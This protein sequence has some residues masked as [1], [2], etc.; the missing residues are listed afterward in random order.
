MNRRDRARHTRAVKT[1]PDTGDGA[2]A[3]GVQD[4]CA[5]AP[6]SLSSGGGPQLQAGDVLARRYELQHLLGTGGMAVV[7][8]AWDQSLERAVAVKILD[9]PM[10]GGLADSE[11]IRR[12]A[13]A[14]ARIDHP[15]AM[16]VYDCGET[17]TPRGRLA[18]YVVMRLLDG[19]SLADR[20]VNDGPLRWQDAVE[21]TS[22]MAEVLAAAHVRGIIHRDVTPE[23]VMLTDEG[24]KLL[25][26]GIAAQV[27]EREDGETAPMFGTPP[28]VAPE[29]LTGAKAEGATDVYALGVMLFEM[30]TGHTPYPEMT[31]AELETADRSGPPPR[32][33]V[34]GMPRRVARLCRRCI[35]ADPMVRPSAEEITAELDA[36]LE[37]EPGRNTRRVRRL[38]YVAAGTVLLVAVPAAF[39][40]PENQA[41]RS[42]PGPSSTEGVIGSPLTSTTEPVSPSASGSPAGP[43][44]TA[45]A[46]SRLSQAP[47]PTP[48]VGPA[49]RVQQAVADFHAV[50]AK[51]LEDKTI[52]KDVASDLD[53]QVNNLAAS[54]YNVG[55][56]IDDLRHKVQARLREGGMQAPVAAQLDTQLVALGAALTMATNAASSGPGH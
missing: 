44:A 29:R 22:R 50:T 45:S 40:T 11:L 53:Q 9:A 2:G 52:R 4:V 7:W 42:A 8:K 15:Y 43:E 18:A 28:Y 36:V 12:E 19:Q 10:T 39:L 13:R 21:I 14:A 32:P 34:P 41:D 1:S 49:V 33:R 25:D 51:G 38:L 31:W 56:Q 16:G 55:A 20:L 27:G 37:L 6:S 35:A 46:T 3:A 54:P 17:I 24:P 5:Q 23:N 30:L 26:F 48:P 47:S